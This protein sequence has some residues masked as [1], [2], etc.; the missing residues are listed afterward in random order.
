M[1][2]RFNSFGAQSNRGSHPFVQKAAQRINKWQHA[3]ADK[4]QD[5][6]ERLSLGTKKAILIAF[7]LLFGGASGVITWRAITAHQAQSAVLIHPIVVSPPAGGLRD[8]SMSPFSERISSREYQIV[9]SFHHYLDSLSGSPS[10]EIVRDS[11]LRERPG[12]LDS[13]MEIENLYLK[14]EK[15]GR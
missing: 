4:L 1:K 13:L 6:S 5:R 10:G 15:A 7:V 8:K 3:C 12:L 9:R 14:E 11:I 2:R